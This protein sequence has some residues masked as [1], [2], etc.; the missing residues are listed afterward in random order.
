MSLLTPIYLN[1]GF[2]PGLTY[3]TFSRWSDKGIK[4]LGDLIA[5]GAMMS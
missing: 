1:Q 3:H 2:S 4:T 5:D